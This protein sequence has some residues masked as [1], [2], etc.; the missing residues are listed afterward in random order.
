MEQWLPIKGIPYYEVS[1]QGRIKN[2]RTG[3]IL[4]HSLDRYGYPKL[5]MTVNGTNYW[6][7][8]HRCVAETWLPQINYGLHVNH[9]NGI[10]TDNCVENLEW[11][12]PQENI[13]HSFDNLLNPNTNPVDLIDFSDNSTKSFRSIKDLSRHLE[14]YMSV[15]S[16]LIKNSYRNPLFGKYVVSVKDEEALVQTFNARHF[17]KPVYVFDEISEQT[18]SYPSILSAAYFTGIRCLG[19][20][21]EEGGYI[22]HIG[23]HVAF[24]G[25]LLPKTGIQNKERLF[26]EREK[27]LTTPYKPR[28]SRYYLYD[29]YKGTE[30]VFE[31]L[32]EVLEFLA[33]V[34]PVQRVLSKSDLSS[35]LGHCTRNNKTGLIKGLGFKSDYHDYEWFPY[36]EEVVLSNKYGY[37]API[38]IYRVVQDKQSELVFGLHGLREKFNYRLDNRSDSQAHLR[39]QQFVNIPNLSIVRLNTPVKNESSC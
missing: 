18:A 29:Y 11:V 33:A 37:P 2:S 1:N 7:T 28:S 32:G 39:I 38:R 5:H 23:Y 31:D 10:K 24:D 17:G 4:K 36:S 21:K 8:I 6:R 14:V 9:K 19:N 25:D 34:E 27:Y 12:T 22:Y 15:L 26:A 16:P 30:Y 13:I 20:I 35:T 3:H